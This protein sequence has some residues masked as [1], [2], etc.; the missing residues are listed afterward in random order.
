[1]GIESLYYRLIPFSYLYKALSQKLF[2]EEPSV[3]VSLAER[4]S[5][6]LMQFIDTL[7]VPLLP[8]YLSVSSK[9]NSSWWWLTTDLEK[10]ENAIV[11]ALVVNIKPP[12]KHTEGM[13][14]VLS[15][16]YL[17]R[18]IMLDFQF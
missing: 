6:L 10:K 12:Q 7:W 11:R 4:Q 1:M 13:F 9:C 8:E 5:F 3:F 15:N 18:L 16:Q 14:H 17:Y 2:D